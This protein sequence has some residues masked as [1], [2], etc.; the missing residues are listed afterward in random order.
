MRLLRA[1]LRAR[2]R[3]QPLTAGYEEHRRPLCIVLGVLARQD[4][5]KLGPVPVLGFLSFAVHLA[6]CLRSRSLWCVFWLNWLGSH[7]ALLAVSGGD[8]R[9]AAL[10]RGRYAPFAAQCAGF[11]ADFSRNRRFQRDC[12]SCSSPS[13]SISLSCKTVI[14]IFYS[15]PSHIGPGAIKSAAFGRFLKSVVPQMDV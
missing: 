12:T 6:S 4:H 8:H 9:H 1:R 3:E 5:R 7:P 13:R 2:A 15:S 14:P 10:P 11:C